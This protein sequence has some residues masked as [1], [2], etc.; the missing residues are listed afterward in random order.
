MSINNQ[1]VSFKIMSSDAAHKERKSLVCENTLKQMNC[2]LS[3]ASETVICLID[4]KD[5]VLA[6]EGQ[7]GFFSPVELPG[8]RYQIPGYFLDSVVEF[9]LRSMTAER[10]HDALIYIHGSTSSSEVGLTLTLAHEIQHFVQYA[11]NRSTWVTDKLLQKLRITHEEEFR[12]SVDFPI[13][14]EARVVSK[15]VAIEMHGREAVEGF[16]RQ[17]R[18]KRITEKDVLDCDFLLSSEADLPYNATKATGTLVERFRSELIALQAQ[19]WSDFPEVKSLNL[20]S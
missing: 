3:Q 20:T 1:A 17:E 8:V 19:N 5:Y 18:A 10:R 14:R 6:K 12:Q 11:T 9:N 16:I 15:R 2:D 13:E 4:D 7:K